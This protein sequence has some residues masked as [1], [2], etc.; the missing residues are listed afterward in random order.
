MGKVEIKGFPVEEISHIYEFPFKLILVVKTSIFQFRTNHN[1]LYTKR[2]VEG[3]RFY[4]FQSKKKKKMTR[5]PI[6]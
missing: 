6:G 2:G 1:I 3:T 4:L 5:F